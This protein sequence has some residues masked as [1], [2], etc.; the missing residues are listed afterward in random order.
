M[1]PRS[2]LPVVYLGL[3]LAAG[4]WVG[5]R[6]EPVPTATAVRVRTK[7]AASSLKKTSVAHPPLAI[8]K[9]QALE[10]LKETPDQRALRLTKDLSTAEMLVTLREMA[11][12]RI[13][14]SSEWT[15]LLRSLA[16]RDLSAAMEF[17]KS[18]PQG[19]SRSAAMGAVLVE[20]AKTQPEEAIK[21]GQLLP[22][23]DRRAAITSVL[24]K[25]AEVDAPAAI[26]YWNSH[27]DLTS[28]GSSFTIALSKL[29]KTEPAK[30]ASLALG[31]RAAIAV[32]DNNYEL[33]RTLAQW[34]GQDLSGAK[35]WALG[36]QHPQQRDMALGSLARSLIQT[37]PATA[38]E[39]ADSM[40]SVADREGLAS[41]LL[42]TWASVDPAAA[43]DYVGKLEPSQAERMGRKLGY[44]LA[45][46]PLS[47]AKALLSR[48][49]E[50]K[51]RQAIVD[52][53]I[54]TH[55]TKGRY[56]DVIQMLNDMPSSTERD[57][58]LHQLAVEWT[59]KDAA[60][61]A[62]WLKSKPDNSDRDILI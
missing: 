42:G 49:P 31:L 9:Q 29:V 47:E 61:V 19:V 21:Q 13:G 45:D 11:S 43:V 18:L 4:Y 5:H 60:A 26:A 58:S 52:D 14:F 8:A 54:R 32:P 10:Q 35:Q 57:R 16:T 55:T 56:V 40:Q 1:T 37:Q 17:A 30:A 28:D 20:L 41:S 25:W 50:G 3:G 48:L 38:F 59:K 51:S 33:E 12:D 44:S 22:V 36:L 6:A 34:A 24:G 62:A 27:P 23:A 15:P 39:M 2:F 7:A 46:L 53:M